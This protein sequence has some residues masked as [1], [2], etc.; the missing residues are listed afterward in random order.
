MV[1][2]DIK[3]TLKMSVTLLI[4]KSYN[5]YASISNMHK[6]MQILNIQR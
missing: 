2:F 6:G 4:V 3:V 1:T 5:K